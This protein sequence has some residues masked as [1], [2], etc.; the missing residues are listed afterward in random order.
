MAKLLAT[1]AQ[2]VTKH[3]SLESN[4]AGDNNKYAIGKEIEPIL[5]CLAANPSVI[6][7]SEWTVLKV[8]FS[9]R[10]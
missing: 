4:T 7:V 8:Y 1:L 6:L 3:P 10:N 9:S 5:K 2:S